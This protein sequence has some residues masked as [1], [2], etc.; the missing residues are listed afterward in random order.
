[1]RGIAQ[2]GVHPPHRRKGVRRQSCRRALASRRQGWCAQLG[3]NI[4][5]RDI[6]AYEKANFVT[7]R[8]YVSYQKQ[9]W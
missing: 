3:V 6:A 5:N 7:I 9:A 1:M 4:N 8:R 2:L